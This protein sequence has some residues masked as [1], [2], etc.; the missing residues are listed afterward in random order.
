MICGFYRRTPEE[1]GALPPGDLMTMLDGID[2]T[3]DREWERAMF[4]RSQDHRFAQKILD[5]RYP[6]FRVDPVVEVIEPDPET[7]APPKVRTF[8]PRANG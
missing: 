8:T 6:R 4:L 5:L 7:E 2:W 3:S 1:V